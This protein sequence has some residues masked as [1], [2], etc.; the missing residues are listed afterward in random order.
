MSE[1][2]ILVVPGKKLT[3][4]RPLKRSLQI[5]RRGRAHRG[6]GARHPHRQRAARAA[7]TSAAGLGH[8]GDLHQPHRHSRHHGA[9]GVG[10]G[11]VR[12]LAARPRTRQV[13]SSICR[14]LTNT[15]ARK[16]CGR[17]QY[18]SF[19]CGRESIR[20]N[21]REDTAIAASSACQQRAANR[22]AAAA[23]LAIVLDGGN[24][25]IRADAL[26]RHLADDRHGRLLDGDA[27]IELAA[28]ATVAIGLLDPNGAIA[29]HALVR[30]LTHQ[31]GGRLAVID[32]LRN[33]ATAATIEKI[34]S[35]EV[36][37]AMLVPAI[38][39]AATRTP[40]SPRIL[41]LPIHPRSIFQCLTFR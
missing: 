15:K 40:R 4:P 13:E 34:A 23:T 25:A 3:V 5:A 2:T 9:D 22:L 28:A 37:T 32:P 18:N 24:G 29:A 10:D 19:R 26:E 21:A 31:R 7:R 1:K 16:S 39:P 17:G 12:L 41:K 14:R 36:V 30:H 27:A 8:L 35:A 33:G 20:W 11:V 38:T 6:R